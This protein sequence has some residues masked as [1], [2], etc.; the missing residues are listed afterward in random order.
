MHIHLISLPYDSARAHWRM[1]NGPGA[2]LRGGLEAALH[3]GGH[4]TTVTQIESRDPEPAE[5]KTAFELYRSLAV[6][7]RAGCAA[8]AEASSPAFTLVLSG[9]CGAAVG[10]VSGL[11][12]DPL[13]IVW[14]DAHGDFNTPDST[15]SGFLDGMGLAIACGQCWTGLARSIPGFRPVPGGN[16]LHLGGSDIEATEAGLMD[17]CGVRR[18]STR[19]IHE[20]GLET[21]LTPAL[22]ALRAKV[23][24]VYI[25][26][27]LDV[28]DPVQTPANHFPAKDGLA[29]GTVKDAIRRI[30]ARFNIRGLGVASYDPAF[31]P[32]G[33]TLRAGMELIEAALGSG[34]EQRF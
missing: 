26:L 21:L 16:A 17:L 18:I 11:P 7:V 8:A 29:A 12:V 24:D 2:F 13:G 19:E 9:N 30:K 28:L 15:S 3:A 25:L 23:G 20:E 10:A 34:D 31:D 5:I 27:D 4:S 6:E 1:G 33:S 32:T 22:D 14:F